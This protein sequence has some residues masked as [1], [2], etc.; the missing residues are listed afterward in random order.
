MSDEPRKP[1]QNITASH[2]TK[3][4]HESVF[5]RVLLEAPPPPREVVTSVRSPHT[6]VGSPGDG[7]FDVGVTASASPV[8]EIFDVIDNHAL[9]TAP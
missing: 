8:H 9:M 1:P 3:T 4:T 5:H 2:T 6:D 7:E